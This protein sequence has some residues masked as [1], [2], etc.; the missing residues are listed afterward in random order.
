MKLDRR[1]ALKALGATVAAGATVR[2]LAPLA[3]PLGALTADAFFQRH[4]KQLDRDQVAA[5][6]GRIEA[7]TRSR[8]GAEVS[9]ED[10]RPT[11][12]V[13]FGYALNLSTC[14]GNRRCVEACHQEN[15]HD[16]D[17][18]GS[19]I[20]VLEI[21][22]GSMALN[23]SVTDYEHPV[24]QPGKFYLPVQCMQC[25]NPPCVHVC[26]VDATWKE[27]D[28]IV[29]VDYDWCIGCRYCQT[30]CP[31][32]ARRFNWRSPR[33]P[34]AEVNPDQAL[35]SNRIRPAGVVEKC[36]FCL[37]RT[38]KGQLPACLEACPTGARVFGNLADPDSEIRW[39][40]ENKR[41]FVLKADLGTQ[42]RFFYYFDG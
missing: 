30:A 34:A 32:Q 23:R 2:A 3:D 14:N 38:R 42:P 31:Y 16:R 27:P 10:V 20:R 1:R 6:I 37:H 41:V 5:L 19:Y 8:Y 9:V 24:P 13:E 21:E 7:D 35:L 18:S 26:P 40:L 39:I 28:G 11:P 36:H 4:Y 25:D 33:I 17:T 15:N 22:N 29:V 12:G